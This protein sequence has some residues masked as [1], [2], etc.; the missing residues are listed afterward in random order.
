MRRAASCLRRG[1]QQRRP[2]VGAPTRGRRCGARRPPAAG[3][4]RPAHARNI[5]ALRLAHAMRMQPRLQGVP[6]PAPIP[7]FGP[8][9]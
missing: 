5:H 3:A 7:T 9:R 2:R 1:H 4:G 6:R 8:A